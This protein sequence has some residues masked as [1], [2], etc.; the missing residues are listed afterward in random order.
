MCLSIPYQIKSISGLTATVK[1]YQRQ[2][3][4]IQ[5]NLLK[6]ARRGD[7][8]T[9]LNGYAIEKITKKEAKDIIN[10]FNTYE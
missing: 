8:V 3:K 1:N 7:W 6:D 9:V 2:E 5:V 10:I 4:L